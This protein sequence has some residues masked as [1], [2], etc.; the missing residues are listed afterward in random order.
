MS[1][2][3]HGRR[4]LAVRAR[5][6]PRC[7]SSARH[8]RSFRKHAWLVRSSVRRRRGPLFVRPLTYIFSFLS[9]VFA[10]GLSSIYPVCQSRLYLDNGILSSHFSPP[11]SLLSFSRLMH[12]SRPNPTFNPSTKY[13]DNYE[14][15]DRQESPDFFGRD[16]R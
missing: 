9:P 2:P 11:S 4:H 13:T 6:F 15:T 3:L 10:A 14:M 5:L 16:P 12:S 1:H 8:F 7:P